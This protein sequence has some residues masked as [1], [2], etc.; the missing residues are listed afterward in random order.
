MNKKQLNSAYGKMAST[1]KKP[2]KSV[3]LNEMDICAM[4]VRETPCLYCVHYKECLA[5]DYNPV[6]PLG[7]YIAWL[8]LYALP[9]IESKLSPIC[10]KGIILEGFAPFDE[11]YKVNVFAVIRVHNRKYPNSLVC[12][13]LLEEA[14]K[15]IGQLTEMVLQA[16][17]YK[18]GK[19]RK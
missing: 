17:V 3:S 10:G 12:R 4:K 5:N 1:S 14:V 6:S 16:Y 8:D 15:D 11:E 18:K 7:A 19:E 2:I 13:V 9:I